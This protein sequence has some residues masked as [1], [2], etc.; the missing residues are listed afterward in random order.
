MVKILSKSIFL[1]VTLGL[2]LW[3]SSTFEQ[4][5]SLLLS[6]I[7]CIAFGPLT[8]WQ[9]RLMPNIYALVISLVAGVFLIFPYG[10]ESSII[11]FVGVV[12]IYGIISVQL[13]MALANSYHN[14]LYVLGKFKRR[15]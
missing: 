9:I 4:S 5:I 13:S 6:L 2:L 3:F 15:K 14:V 12:F 10:L 8:V 11:Y 7:A 1:G